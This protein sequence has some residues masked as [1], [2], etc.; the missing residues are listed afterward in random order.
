[1]TV[2][3]D[4]AR[5]IVDRASFP[6]TVKTHDQLAE[7]V[8]LDKD[9]IEA[10]LAEEWNGARTV[11]RRRISTDMPGSVEEFKAL[12]ELAATEARD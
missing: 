8:R 4:E 2:S 5:R 1:M 9:T 10:A 11:L 3:I 12:W 6:P 7:M